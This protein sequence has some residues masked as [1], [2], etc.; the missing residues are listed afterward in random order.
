[1]KS[2]FK[3][4]FLA[5]SAIRLLP[6]AA[7]FA[8]AS[9]EGVIKADICRWHQINHQFTLS[10]FPRSIYY[11]L[12]LMTYVR[13]YRNVFYLRLGW[14]ARF[15]SWLCPPIAT[16]EID[17]LSIGP[18]LFVQHGVASLISAETIGANFWVNQQVSIGYSNAEDRPTIGDN[19][20]V[21]PGA[22]IIGKIRIG[23]NATVG[24]NTVVVSDVPDGATVFGVPAKIIWRGPPPAF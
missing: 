8:L 19:V 3:Q 7:I 18:G 23:D 10:G 11:F 5:I 20:T 15:I 9:K 13:E 6:S 22:K 1:M 4:I 14:R 17:A 12:Y 24:L 21:R 16:L 2:L